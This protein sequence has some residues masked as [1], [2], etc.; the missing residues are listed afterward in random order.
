MFVQI[1]VNWY[2]CRPMETVIT[3][4]ILSKALSFDQYLDLTKSIV[5]SAVPQGKYANEK[6]F[7]YTRSNLE[8][9]E[10]VLREMVLNQKLY[11]LLGEIKE[12]WL[13][14]VI[15][16]PWC[17]D[18]SWGTPALYMISTGT[19]KID[20]S[21]LLRDEHPEIIRA[22]QTAGSDSIP[23]LICFRKADMLELGTWGPRPQQLQEIVMAFKKHPDFEYKESVRQLHAWYDEDMTKSIQEELIDLI[24]DWKSK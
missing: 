5:N 24:K 20:F 19:E 12:D 9:M 16:E 22:Y 7:R 13:W 23:K 8:R 15:S 17:G 1:Y 2:I 10:K 4:E 14:L 3:N 21:I 18:A 6:T 11:N